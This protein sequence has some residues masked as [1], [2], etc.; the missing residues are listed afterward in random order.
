MLRHLLGIKGDRIDRGK[1]N[2][3]PVGA[4]L[5]ISPRGVSHPV[6]LVW[7]VASGVEV[8]VGIR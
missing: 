1:Y 5:A 3:L 8:L 4:P 7:G 2:D 6:V